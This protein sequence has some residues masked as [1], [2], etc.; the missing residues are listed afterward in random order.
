MGRF[1]DVVVADIDGSA[2]IAFTAQ[3]A[4]EAGQALALALDIADAQAV[5]ALFETAQ[6]HFDARAMYLTPHDR[7]ILDLDPA[8]W[9]QTMV[10]KLRGAL[11]CCR[12]AIPRM[13]ARGVGVIVNM[14][15]CQGLSGDTAQ[16]SYAASKAA[17][18]MLSASL[19]TQYV[20]T[21][22]GASSLRRRRL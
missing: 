13:I 10:T 17:M 12:Q 21:G 22:A 8:V 16:T 18:N 14:S 2:A 15:S 4:A 9:D 1:E 7:A 19:A 11:F 6:R 3:I 20:R 5:A